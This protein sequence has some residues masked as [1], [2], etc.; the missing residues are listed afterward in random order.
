MAVLENELLMA[1]NALSSAQQITALSSEIEGLE[2]EIRILETELSASGSVKTLSDIQAEQHQVQSEWQAFII[3]KL[4]ALLTL[5]TWCSQNLRRDIDRLNKDLRDK[6]R[7]IQSKESHLRSAQEDLQKAKTKI[8]ETQKM[9]EAI[10]NLNE[11]IGKLQAEMEAQDQQA[12]QYLP[13]IEQ[14]EKEIKAFRDEKAQ[15][16]SGR[17][18]GMNTLQQT[19]NQINSLDDEVQR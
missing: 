12:S 6:Q 5:K 9:N 18:S 15:Q 17:V 16:E 19:L 3:L 8:Q 10:T 14:K 4:S 1:K 2:K 11:E 13:V 7:E